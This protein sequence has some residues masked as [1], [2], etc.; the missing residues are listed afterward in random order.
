[1]MGI[2]EVLKRVAVSRPGNE[3]AWCGFAGPPTAQR[4]FGGSGPRGHPMPSSFGI[5]IGTATAPPA[6]GP[7]EVVR[8]H[9]ALERLPWGLPV[10]G[11]PWGRGRAAVANPLA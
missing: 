3:K 9:C 8:R 10:I 2:C 1:M 5:L 7:A 6:T 4:R 11:W